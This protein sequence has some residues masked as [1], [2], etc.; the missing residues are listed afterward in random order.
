[1]G[2]A[3]GLG[4]KY[5]GIIERAEKSPSFEAIE[6]IARALAVE[7]YELFVPMNRRTDGVKRQ[8]QALLAEPARLNPQNIEEFLKAMTIALRKL[9]R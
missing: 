6:K 8:V 9:D 5:I 7:S 4:G 2:K 1:M 3:A